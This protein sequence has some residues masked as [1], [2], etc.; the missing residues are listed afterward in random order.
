MKYYGAVGYS[1]TTETVPGVWE[2]QITERYYYGDVLK[3]AR[4]WEPASDQQNDNLR[5]TNQFSIIAD[6]FALQHFHLIRYITYA[7]TKWKVTEASI[8]GRRLILSV[9]DV[10]NGDHEED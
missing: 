2:E 10:Y 6:P 7:G 4:R 1:V 9:G 5:I 3:S 8:D